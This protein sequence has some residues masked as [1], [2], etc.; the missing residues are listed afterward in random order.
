L[1]LSLRRGFREAWI[2]EVEKDVTAFD[3]YGEYLQT[4]AL[5]IY[6]TPRTPIELPMVPG[7]TKGLSYQVALAQ[8][9][10]LVRTS[11]SI[12]VDVVLDVDQENAVPTHV[13]G[14]HF[15]AP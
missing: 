6:A 9:A 15:A 1:V 13:K 14:Q 2:I 10:F 3:T 8:A 12:R 5:R 4:G 7:A 11:I